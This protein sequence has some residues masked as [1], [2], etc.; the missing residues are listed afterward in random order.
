MQQT[1]IRGAF[2]S[3]P[4][5]QLPCLSAETATR[6]YDTLRAGKVHKEMRVADRL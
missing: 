3:E 1:L 6:G 4:H 2:I 5:W